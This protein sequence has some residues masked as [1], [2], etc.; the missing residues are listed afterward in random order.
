MQFWFGIQFNALQIQVLF[1]FAVQNFAQR[2]WWNTC[3]CWRPTWCTTSAWPGAPRPLRMRYV[4]QNFWL[5]SLLDYCLVQFTMKGSEF[6]QNCSQ[7]WQSTKG[8]SS[9]LA[10][11]LHLGLALAQIHRYRGDVERGV[12]PYWGMKVKKVYHLQDNEWWIFVF[13]N[14][15]LAMVMGNNARVELEDG[16]PGLVERWKR[17]LILEVQCNP[18]NGSLRTMIQLAY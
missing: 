6:R 12:E 7:N 1:H 9:T 18:L 5:Y 10:G 15:N 3:P 4:S 8:S 17:L 14:Q 16:R 11:K 2:S 13:S